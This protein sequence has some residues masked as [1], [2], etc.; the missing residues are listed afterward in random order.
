[1]GDG[2]LRLVSETMLLAEQRCEGLNG[3][4]GR[5]PITYKKAQRRMFRLMNVRRFHQGL[6]LHTLYVE[7]RSNERS[8]PLSAAKMLSVVKPRATRSIDVSTPG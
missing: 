1:M 4:C 2:R 6:F 5:K 7:L 8:A 3:R